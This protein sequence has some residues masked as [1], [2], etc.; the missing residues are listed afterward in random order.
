MT[1]N[2]QRV[3]VYTAVFTHRPVQ[4]NLLFRMDVTDNPSEIGCELSFV[5]KE[6]R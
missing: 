5:D 4:G 3:V 6:D 2:P 1:H